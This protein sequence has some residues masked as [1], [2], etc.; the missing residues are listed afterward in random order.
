MTSTLVLVFASQFVLVF[1]LGF[2]S[3]NVNGGHY[4]AAAVSSILIG[5]TSLVMYK[6][7]PEADALTMAVW[8]AAGPLAI[9]SS[10]WVHRHFSW[11]AIVG[12]E[13]GGI[14]TRVDYNDVTRSRNEENHASPSQY[15]PVEASRTPVSSAVAFRNGLAHLTVPREGVALSCYKQEHGSI[16]SDSAQLSMPSLTRGDSVCSSAPHDLAAPQRYADGS[17]CNSADFTRAASLNYA[18]SQELAESEQVERD[19]VLLTTPSALAEPSEAGSSSAAVA[20]S[21]K[22]GAQ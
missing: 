1:A 7:L 13:V 3:L 16:I 12:A 20:T 2:Q 8:L 15:I 14:E 4:V 17:S 11:W 10:M 9:V 22:G 18:R 21:T 5:A 19:A 6:V